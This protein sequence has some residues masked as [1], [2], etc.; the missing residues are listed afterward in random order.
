MVDAAGVHRRLIKA[1]VSFGAPSSAGWNLVLSSGDGETL[2]AEVIPAGQKDVWPHGFWIPTRAVRNSQY[3]LELQRGG[4]VAEVANVRIGGDAAAVVALPFRMDRLDRSLLTRLESRER[5]AVSS[6]DIPVES[7]LS[8]HD[9]VYRQPSPGWDE[10]LPLGNGDVG[11]LVSGTK[12]EQIFFLDKTDIWMATEEGQALGRSYAG[13]LRIRYKPNGLQQKS[14]LQRLSLAR[15]EVETR[16]GSFRSIA[17][18]NALRNQFEVE[19]HDTDVEISLERTPV[20]LWTDKAGSYKNASRLYGSWSVGLKDEVLR[21]MAA[22]AERAPH[23]RVE[24]GRGSDGCWF[25]HTIPNLRYG[26][27]L[28]VENAQVQWTGTDETCTARL[29]RTGEG[30]I[31]VRTAIATGRESADPLSHARQIQRVDRDRHIAWWRRFWRRS[32]IDIPDKLEE[33]LWYLGVYQQAACSRSDQAVSFFGLWHPL[34]HRTWYDAYAHDAQVQM[35]WWLPFATNHLELL[36]PS[37]RTFGGWTVEMAEHTPSSGMVVTG[38]VPEWAGG[39]GWFTGVNPYKGTS[40]WYTMN[41]WWDY[42]YS[43]DRDFLRE[44]TYPMMRMVADYY[45]EVLSKGADGRY[46]STDSGSPEQ[47]GADRDTMYDWAM[48]KWFFGAILEASDTLGIDSLERPRWREIRDN[49]FAAPGDGNT[50]WETPTYAHPYRCHPVVFYGLYPTW[51]ITP[52]SKLFEAARRTVPVATRLIG[53]RYQ[54]R[55]STIP[56]FEGG[57]EPNG[58]SSGSL[59]IFLARLGDYEQ[60]RRF[61]YGLIVRFHMKQN[62]LRSQTDTR[63]TDAVSRASLV[64]AANANTVATTE[65]LLQSWPDHVRLFPCR[66]AKGR[67][68]FAGL[69]AAGGF[70]IAAEALNGRF[71]WATVKSLYGGKLRLVAPFSESI[72]AR[73]QGSREKIDVA[74]FKTEDGK[75]G[76]ELPTDAGVVYEF[77][78]S[79]RT[80][81]AVETTSVVERRDPWKISVIEAE[82]QGDRLA[83]YPSNLPFGQIVRDGNLYLG[84]PASYGQ[85]PRGPGTVALL[86]RSKHRDWQVRMEAARLLARSIPGPEMLKALDRLCSDPVNVVAHTAGVTLVQIG[87]KESIQIAREHAAKNSVPGLNREVQKA[88]IRKS[89]PE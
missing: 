47:L 57:L 67:I 31:V 14:F 87:S 19:V 44:V 68:R 2:D 24:W 27:V 34:E 75:S 58:H 49:L 18:V 45:V 78:V 37:H 13:S 72:L 20:T 32:W 80:K 8:Q 59:V 40:A 10:G 85:P 79:D 16:D 65:T 30:P 74:V 51:Q 46:H 53:Y 42:L 43:G 9:V 7:Y 15:A 11:A 5:E 17:R 86:A 54:D 61:F 3:R 73:R 64:E 70:V 63:H 77:L 4:K 66:E 6:F 69:R 41:F 89:R 71:Q 60:Y 25:L 36:Y 81:I 50:L 35:M 33:N 52:G 56:G 84:S 38:L 29:R 82:N 55:H 12:G 22:D 88:L 1:K 23:T 26:V 76:V 28:Q 83:H 39:H 62:G 48:L 21:K